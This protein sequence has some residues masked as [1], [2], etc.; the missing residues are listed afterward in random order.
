VA[1]ERPERVAREL[2]LRLL[3]GRARSRAEL[4][5]A[6]LRRGVP[7][8]VVDRVLSRFAEAGLVDDRALAEAFVSSRH[9]GQGLARR[10]LSDQL[11]HRGVDPLTASAALASLDEATETET[12]RRLVRHQLAANRSLAVV[13][14]ARR[15]VGMLARKGYPRHVAYRVVREELAAEDAEL[16]DDVLTLLTSEDA[17]DPDAQ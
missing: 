17:G 8:E 7:A 10:A 11:G 5:G 12:A 4:A 16:P 15:L 14:R 3:A 2:C 9:A 1:P 13:V 6:L